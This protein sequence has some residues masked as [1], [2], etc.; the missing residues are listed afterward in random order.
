M[1]SVAKLG[2]KKPPTPPLLV[3]D[4]RRAASSS[5]LS[6]YDAISTA[7]HPQSMT[8]SNMARP[9]LLA[10]GV[11]KPLPKQTLSDKQPRPSGMVL[12]QYPVQEPSPT[13]S[14]HTSEASSLL[15]SSSSSSS[16]SLS[17]LR[18][19]SASAKKSNRDPTSVRKPV[20]AAPRETTASIKRKEAAMARLA[21]FSSSSSSNLSSGVSG[22]DLDTDGA[23]KIREEVLYRSPSSGSQGQGRNRA[24]TNPDQRPLPRPRPMATE[25]NAA[26]LR[27][28]YESMMDSQRNHSDD[29]EGI[30]QAS[31]I[32]ALE[33]QNQEEHE[34]AVAMAMSLATAAGHVPSYQHLHGHHGP[35]S[36]DRSTAGYWTED[37]IEVIDG[38]R[39]PVAGFD[40]Q[41]A[42]V[43]DAP[44]EY[45]SL[46]QLED[47]KQG[48]RP[49]RIDQFPIGIVGETLALDKIRGGEELG[50][51]CV[52]MEEFKAGDV[53]R[54]LPCGH[55]EFCM[56][57]IDKWFEEN[58]KCPICKHWCDESE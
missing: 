58:K 8:R 33:L 56:D 36:E 1:G 39:S 37:G 10:A 50:A 27:M 25:G 30:I 43:L 51:C 12:F 7:D 26:R 21:A 13:L 40:G 24:Y 2:A 48:L 53:V 4:S 20:A 29:L 6:R 49:E 22:G 46:L 41:A 57:C 14:T 44:G 16:S 32:S 3:V 28:L 17:V 35:Y 34:L 52:C 45:E 38:S 42:R 54:Q 19:R 18:P 5:T 31:S 47:V 11:R 9:P 55:W 23:P 15:L